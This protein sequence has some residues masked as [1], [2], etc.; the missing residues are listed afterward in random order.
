LKA[1]SRELLGASAGAKLLWTIECWHAGVLIEFVRV[2]SRI[3]VPSPW[4]DLSGRH[5]RR[6]RDAYLAFS[7]DGD[8]P[9]Y[10]PMTLSDARVALR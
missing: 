10:F 8:A 1:D 9:S 6:R 3:V 4:H 7:L 2:N 5:W